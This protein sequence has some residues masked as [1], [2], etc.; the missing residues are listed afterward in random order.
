VV[1]LLATSGNA[2]L[3]LFKGNFRQGCPDQHGF[4]ELSETR[5]IIEGWRVQDNTQRPHPALRYGTPAA[6]AAPGEE[7]EK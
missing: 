6:F 4:A 7:P 5:Q 1:A 2:F 3:E